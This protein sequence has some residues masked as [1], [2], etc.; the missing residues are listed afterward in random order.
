MSLPAAK[1]VAGVDVLRAVSLGMRGD[2]PLS[3]IPGV[4]PMD[5]VRF[6]RLLFGTARSSKKRGGGQERFFSPN[7][8]IRIVKKRKYADTEHH[9]KAG[10]GKW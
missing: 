5:Q 7:F 9:N 3:M 4:S 2:E 8:T 10:E 6:L 1:K